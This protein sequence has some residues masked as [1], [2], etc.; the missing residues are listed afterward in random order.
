M[1]NPSTNPGTAACEAVLENEITY[2]ETKGETG[3]ILPS[4]TAVARRLLSHRLAL[5]SAYQ[6]LECKLGPY[7]RALPTFL[8]V[9]LSA[10]AHWAPEKLQEAREDRARLGE[11]NA[12]IATLARELAD[13]L[14]QR[15]SLHNESGF[16]ANTLYHPVDLI[17]AA[18]T[19]NGR[20]RS[21]IREPLGNLATQFDLKYWPSL[22]DMCAAL[23]G[24][25]EAAQVEATDPLTAAGT[26][27]QRASLTSFVLALFAGV[28]ENRADEYGP[29]PD[30]FQPTDET[31]AALVSSALDLSPDQI[32][33]AEYIKGIR[34]RQ[35]RRR[36]AS[37]R[38]P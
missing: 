8:G 38:C 23:A 29:L 20:F 36:K 31:W 24:D 21:Y 15:E 7:D 5:S 2:N 32:I 18:S 12:R 11:L 14:A 27:G 16:A 35:R 9:V 25:A 6:E 10:V 17:E 33:G 37:P 22:G 3:A 1:P 26:E 13:S 4:E 28:D 34:Q 19:R 30:D